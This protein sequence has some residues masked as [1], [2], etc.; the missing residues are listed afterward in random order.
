MRIIFL[1][2]DGV[3]VNLSCYGNGQTSDVYTRADARAVAALNSITDA[4]GARIVVSSVWRLGGLKKIRDIL[5]AWGVTG[6]VI[7]C[8]P[9]LARPAE[10]GKLWV[11]VQRGDEIQAW[12][13][14]Y[15]RSP[16]ESFCIIDDDAD[17][18][19]LAGRLIQTDFTDGLT[20][21]H[22]ERAIEMLT[23]ASP[24]LALESA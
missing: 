23:C 16:V 20:T 8:T 24:S 4:T 11:A 15:K 22:A 18:K 9:D 3:L 7:A 10:R 14:S 6:K 12:L 5:R 19:H 2:I 13:D 17:M 1:D 21:A